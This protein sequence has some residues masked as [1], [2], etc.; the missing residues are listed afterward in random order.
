MPLSIESSDRRLL[1]VGGAFLV[2]LCLA[3]A[4]V[5]PPEATGE[6]SFPSTY[7]TAS[8]GARAAF[9]LLQKLG[10]QVRRWEDSPDQ[11]PGTGAGYLLILA[12][13][14][15]AAST[16]E[17]HAIQR[18]VHSGGAVLAV[19]EEAARWM[20][21][22]D[23]VHEETDDVEWKSYAAQSPGPLT[24]DAPRITMAPPSVRWKTS[25]PSHE[26]L[27]ADGQNVVA[28]RYAAG[29]GSVIW[30]ADATPLTN[31]GLPVEG[32]LSFF[33]DCVGSPSQRTILWDEYFHG[34]RRSLFAY[35]A[36]TPVPWAGLQAAF[37]ALLILVT[38]MRRS[39]PVQ[40]P[41]TPSRLSPLEFV[42]TLGDLYHRAHA[43]SAAASVSYAHFRM[44]LARRLGLAANTRLADL[45]RAARERLG[46]TEPGFYE[47]LQ[48][49]ERASRNPHLGDEDALRI[50]EALEHYTG[51]LHL[52]R[53]AV[54]ENPQWRNT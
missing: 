6:I 11:L 21:E 53:Q 41:P 26:A 12:E 10:Y 38:F 45:H 4:A 43:G 18:F 37:V 3:A 49:A 2:L 13:P 27:Y 51:L 14:F 32:N 29:K 22:T 31:A 42:E 54:K 1:I 16:E 39:G 24:R 9:A 20:P 7:S 33:L 46:W 17:Q 23:A 52:K 30:W 36:R 44:L 19:G 47:T 25:K 28:V 34:Q 40:A 5:V 35:I 48:A 50:V 8:G 15:H